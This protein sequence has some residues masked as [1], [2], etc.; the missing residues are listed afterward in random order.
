V[1]LTGKDPRLVAVVERL[2]EDLGSDYFV[3]VD[4]WDGDRLAI[5]LTKPDAPGVLVYVAVALDSDD[6]FFVC[7]VPAAELYEVTSSQ[8][9][10]GYGDVLSA[11][12]G[13]LGA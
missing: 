5:G 6:L 3:P 10:A 2:R 4:H 11:V 13:H 9:R 7:E 12:A 1:E 8:E